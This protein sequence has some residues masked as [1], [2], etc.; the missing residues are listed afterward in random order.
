MRD[1]E[2]EEGSLVNASVLSVRSMRAAVI[3][4]GVYLFYLGIELALKCLNCA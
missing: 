1:E 4:C 3:G 2:E